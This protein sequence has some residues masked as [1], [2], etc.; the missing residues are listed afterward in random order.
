MRNMNSRNSIF[1]RAIAPGLALALAFTAC[2]GGSETTSAQSTSTSAQQT[3]PTNTDGIEAPPPRPG[4]PF[5]VAYQDATL[6][7]NSYD[8]PPVA[9]HTYAGVDPKYAGH[10]LFQ[11][12]HGETKPIVCKAIGRD[13][14]PEKGELPRDPSLRP[15]VWFKIGGVVGTQFAPAFYADPIPNVAAIRPCDP[16]DL[17]G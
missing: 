8:N 5:S 3:R 17:T 9:V 7:F 2:S 6:T 1:R 10:P 13:V 11:Y 15:D 4:P 12:K 16:Q 14:E